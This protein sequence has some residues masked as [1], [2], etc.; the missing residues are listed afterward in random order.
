MFIVE[1]GSIMILKQSKNII[2]S[3]ALILC[4]RLEFSK[5]SCFF[6]IPFSFKIKIFQ[7]RSTN[8]W[9]ILG[10]VG[11]RAR[12]LRKARRLQ[13]FVF[14]QDISIELLHGNLTLKTYVLL[15][16]T[17]FY[18]FDI[19]RHEYTDV[20]KYYLIAEKMLDDSVQEK[21]LRMFILL[22]IER[23]Y[24]HTAQYRKT[25]KYTIKAEKIAIEVK[26]NK[27]KHPVAE[28]PINLPEYKNAITYI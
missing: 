23:A 2:N 8:I 10:F 1:S 9:M 5:C 25:L 27:V 22:R 6:R 19:E 16:I 3:S 11:D 21:T 13:Q 14:L 15:Q 26:H 20:L 7:P 4:H 18:D 24:I 28:M 12:K 17:H